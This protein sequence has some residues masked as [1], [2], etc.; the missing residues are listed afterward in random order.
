MVLTLANYAH[1][2]ATAKTGNPNLHRAQDDYKAYQEGIVRFELVF[3]SDD[4]VFVEKPPMLIS[5]PEFLI[6]EGY[7]KVHS[8]ELRP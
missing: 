5:P 8:R 7:T 6:V 1:S 2:D 3:T 4:F